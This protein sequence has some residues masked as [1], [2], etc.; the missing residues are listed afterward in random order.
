MSRVTL[1]KL[2]NL[3]VT[4]FVKWRLKTVPVITG[5][6]SGLNIWKAIIMVPGIKKAIIYMLVV[7]VIIITSHRNVTLM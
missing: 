4:S 1:D 6:F 2:V 5:L 3:F 7:V